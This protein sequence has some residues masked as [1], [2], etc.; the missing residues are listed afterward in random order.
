LAPYGCALRSLEVSKDQ[1][2]RKGTYSE[3]TSASVYVFEGDL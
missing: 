1:L 3:N 2:C